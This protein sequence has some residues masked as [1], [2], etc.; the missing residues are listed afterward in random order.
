[1]HMKLEQK[2][3]LEEFLALPDN[4][5]RRWLVD[6][7]VK[8]WPTDGADLEPPMT[9][10]K[11]FHSRILLRLG[12]VLNN[13]LDTL[14]EP[15]GW[16]VGGE[17]GFIF[18]HEPLLYVG[19]DVGYVSHEVIARQT[20]ETT[21]IDGIPL[22]AVEVLSPSDTLEGIAERRTLYRN[23]RIPLFWFID[24]TEQTVTVHALGEHPRLLNIREEL[25]AEPHLP[26]FRVPVARLFS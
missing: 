23:V 20:D 13:W 12:Q 25:T 2:L 11:R 24:P 26:G 17:A 4:G 7:I 1:M 18:S 16:F 22:L 19:I 21:L 15:R 14:P 10:R 9:V 3:T 5:M 8:E 6:G